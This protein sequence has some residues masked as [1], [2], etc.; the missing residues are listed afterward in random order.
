[1]ECEDVRNN[2]LGLYVLNEDEPGDRALV[3]QHLSTCTACRDFM[4]DMRRTVALLKE[5]GD[6]DRREAVA[7]N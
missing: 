7:F 3:E 1:M 5:V 6:E 2:R 4:W